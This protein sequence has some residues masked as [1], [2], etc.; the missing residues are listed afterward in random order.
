MAREFRAVSCGEAKAWRAA[1]ILLMKEA[2]P[3]ALCKC[4]FAGSEH[5]QAAMWQGPALLAARRRLVCVCGGEGVQRLPC[6]DAP[7]CKRVC[8]SAGV[9]VRAGI[10]PKHRGPGGALWLERY[11][12]LHHGINLKRGRGWR[13]CL[14]PSCPP[15]PSPTA[16]SP[17]H[18]R[19]GRGRCC[20]GAHQGAAATRRG[21]Q[22]VKL[23]RVMGASIPIAKRQLKPCP[24]TLR[25]FTGVAWPV[26][27]PNLAQI[28]R[29]RGFALDHCPGGAA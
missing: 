10:R 18:W 3:V 24:E 9:F 28:G 1:V 7:V 27:S 16:S 2:G 20:L 17:C 21:T 13:I 29:R 26:Q 12:A 23:L 14:V 25:H 11:A 15:G 4:G 6:V 8:S 19:I 5:G 22:Q